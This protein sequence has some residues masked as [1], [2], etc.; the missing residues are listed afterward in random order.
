MSYFGMCYLLERDH[1][2]RN[3]LG[4][5]DEKHSKRERREIRWQYNRKHNNILVCLKRGREAKIIDKS[6]NAS[7][8]NRKG[9]YN[10]S[11][12]RSEHK[13]KN[14]DKHNSGYN[15]NR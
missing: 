6:K 14:K 11:K 5:N 13:D 2:Q 7:V 9:S 15:Y 10:N 8:R 1:K 4:Y 12:N 3:S